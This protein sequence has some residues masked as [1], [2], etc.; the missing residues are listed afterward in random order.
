MLVTEAELAASLEDKSFLRPRKD[1]AIRSVNQMS[2][3]HPGNMFLTKY[4][5]LY[6]FVRR[7]QDIKA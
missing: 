5:V 1:I 3:K 7:L 4:F 6:R 2:S